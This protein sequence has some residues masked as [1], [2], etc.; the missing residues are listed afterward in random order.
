MKKSIYYG[1]TVKFK[2]S[3]GSEHVGVVKS[4]GP[5]W[6]SLE[7]VVSKEIDWV[8]ASNV[9]WPE[10]EAVASLPEAVATDITAILLEHRNGKADWGEISHLEG[11]Q[12]SKKVANRFLLCCLLDYQ[13]D[14]NLAWR[15]GYRLVNEVLGDPD[16]VWAAITSV[17]EAEWA[18]QRDEYHLHRFAAG[19]NRLWRIARSIRA[20]YDG[21]A[22]CI[23]MGKDPSDVIKR[24]WSVGAGEQI[25]RMIV[26]A[27]RDCGQLSGASD[28]KADVYVCR[29]LGR[30]VCG[31]QTTPEIA[32]QLARGLCPSDPWQL[33]WPVWN[34]GK[35]HCHANNPDCSL[36]YLAPHC[37]YALK[38]HSQSASTSNNERA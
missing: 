11:Q 27:L 2:W 36:C 18:S 9:T 31:D 25:S 24:L 30:A 8:V 32:L 33:D 28:V 12:C 37:A 14:S 35:T 29:V 34:V 7:N 21:D 16:D 23:W 5:K 4:V 10:A 1:S 38:A 15:N 6:V 26:G 22:R 3:N 17:T 13:M 20:N 19:H